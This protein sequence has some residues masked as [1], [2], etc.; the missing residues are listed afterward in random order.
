M[1]QR[2]IARSL[3]L[4]QGVVHAYL[5]RARSA[6]LGWRRC[7]FRRPVE[8]RPRTGRSPTGPGCTRSCGVRT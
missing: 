8:P 4:S 7:C 6:G 3:G 1:S 5:R 2:V